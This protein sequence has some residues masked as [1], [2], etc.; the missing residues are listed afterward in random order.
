MAK[1]LFSYHGGKMPEGEEAIAEMMAAWGAWFE[2]MGETVL[3]GGNPVMTSATV[4]SDGSTSDGGGANPVGGYGL[5]EA[6]S[7]DAATEMAKG[8]P[9]LTSGGSVEVG[10][11]ID[12]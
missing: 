4:A 1:Y 10:E 6:A 8:C 9:V 12:M 7:M 2:S 3:D 11:T 5:F